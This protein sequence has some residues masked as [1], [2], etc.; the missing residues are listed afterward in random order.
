[1]NKIEAV[2]DILDEINTITEGTPKE[3]FYEIY[4]L[5][6]EAIQVLRAFSLS[7]PEYP[8][9]CKGHDG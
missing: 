6:G 8:Q 9:G 2:I 7:W 3:P 4:N 1:M 5:S